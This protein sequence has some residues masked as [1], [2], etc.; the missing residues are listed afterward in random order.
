MKRPEPSN[1][2]LT[3]RADPA[4]AD[5]L[6]DRIRRAWAVEPV[7]LLQPGCPATVIEVYFASYEAAALAAEVLRRR[8]GV[9]SADVRRQ[10]H[11]DWKGFWR[12][13]F[14]TFDVGARLRV[15]PAWERKRKTGAGGRRTVVIEPG[16][17]F[18]TGD[19]FTTRFCLEAVEQLC[20]KAPPAALLD[21][22]TGSGILALAAARLGVRRVVAVD[23]DPAALAEA[24]VNAAL[25]HLGGRVAWRETD[26]TRTAPAGRFDVVCANLNSALLIGCAGRLLAA[27]R[28]SLAVSGVLEAEA[29]GVAEAYVSRG[30]REVM[31]DGDGQWAGMVF[32]AARRAAGC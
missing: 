15:R 4:R 2:V 10:A 13:H 26:I 31:R 16:L 30:A 7:Q 22:G 19:H 1:P 18:G 23:S 25:N 32:R 9:I 21:V 29:D 6:C 8:P 28:G 11:R 5:A 27:A 14:H 12:H 17:S 20:R 24:R 3:L